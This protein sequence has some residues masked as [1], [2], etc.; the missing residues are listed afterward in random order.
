M[1]PRTSTQLFPS[2]LKQ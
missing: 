1:T 2:R